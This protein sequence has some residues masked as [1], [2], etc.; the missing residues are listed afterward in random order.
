MNLQTTDNPTK[1]YRVI[2]TLT[3]IPVTD[4]VGAN[5]F[6]MRND[7]IG[8][9]FKIVLSAPMLGIWLFLVLDKPGLEAIGFVALGSLLFAA[10]VIWWLVDIFLVALRK[11]L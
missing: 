11:R 1:N 10:S 3:L 5:W 6:Y 9:L 4:F 2:L 7:S 8:G